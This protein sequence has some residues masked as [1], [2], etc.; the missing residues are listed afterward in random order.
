M[1]LLDLFLTSS[2]HIFLLFL[3]VT[4]DHAHAAS[5]FEAKLDAASQSCRMLQS[6]IADAKRCTPGLGISRGTTTV[7][8]DRDAQ[9][10]ADMKLKNESESNKMQ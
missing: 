7:E 1:L 4:K 10:S 8:S 5:G 2:L 6:A 9:G 3:Q